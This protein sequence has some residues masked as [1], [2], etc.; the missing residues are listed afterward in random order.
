MSHSERRA[1]SRFLC[2]EL[3]RVD[4]EDSDCDEPVQFADAVLEDISALGACVQVE[5]PIGVDCPIRLTI[6]QSV[7]EGRVSYT[8]FRDYGYFVGIRFSE[9]TAWSADTVIPEHLTSLRAIAQ[10]ADPYC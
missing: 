8:V 3:V 7:F 4:W 6:G 2:A 1:E 10:G 5:Q 9:E